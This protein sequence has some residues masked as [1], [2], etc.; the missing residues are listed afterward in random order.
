MTHI[1]T[2]TCHHVMVFT[3]RV[4]EIN[5]LYCV[6]AVLN[7]TFLIFSHISCITPMASIKI[8]LFKQKDGKR[9]ECTRNINI[10]HKSLKK[11]GTNITM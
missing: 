7:I 4:T 2:D 8:K 6:T 1:E 11:S 10:L 3:K 9:L 5:I